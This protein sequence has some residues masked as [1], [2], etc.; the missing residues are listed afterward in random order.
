MT[1]LLD[2]LPAAAKPALKSKTVW[3][4]GLAALGYLIGLKWKPLGDFISENAEL[5]GAALAA[6]NVGFR[7]TTREPITFAVSKKF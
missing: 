4:N 7:A 3:V 6:T 5:F 1:D 2:K